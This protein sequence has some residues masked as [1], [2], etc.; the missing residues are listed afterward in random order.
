MCMCLL[1]QCGA[2][3]QFASVE[4]L[5]EW[6]TQG[7]SA[8]QYLLLRWCIKDSRH[9]SGDKCTVSADIWI[10]W[11]NQ[12]EV[13]WKRDDLG[14]RPENILRLNSLTI[15]AKLFLH[16]VQTQSVN[17]TNVW[18]CMSVFLAVLWLCLWKCTFGDTWNW[19]MKAWGAIK[20]TDISVLGVTHGLRALPRAPLLLANLHLG[21]ALSWPVDAFAICC[22]WL[23][24]VGCIPH[25]CQFWHTTTICKPEKAHQKCVNLRQDNQNWPEWAKILCSPC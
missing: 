18:G 16:S 23:V 24:Q 12:R 15:N 7:P 1:N 17:E 6:L 13:Y 11:P 22:V 14:H 19:D 4:S 3:G 5:T 10:D 2:P 8:L 25:I 20:V 21:T 9:S